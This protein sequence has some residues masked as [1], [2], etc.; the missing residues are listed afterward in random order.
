V[1]ALCIKKYEKRLPTNITAIKYFE[2]ARG[3]SLMG[4]PL[5]SLF[6]LLEDL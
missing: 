2:K 1:I 5:K 4:V 6:L 3:I